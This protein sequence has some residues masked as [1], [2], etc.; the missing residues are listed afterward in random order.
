M[1][2]IKGKFLTEVLQRDTKVNGE[3]LI[4]PLKNVKTILIFLI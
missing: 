2:S 3:E 1:F 4:S